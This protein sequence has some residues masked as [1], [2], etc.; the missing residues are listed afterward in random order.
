MSNDCLHKKS[1][2]EKGWIKQ[3]GN[4][5]C[6]RDGSLLP[7]GDGSMKSKVEKI[8]GQQNRS[9]M[10]AGVYPMPSRQTY[11]SMYVNKERDRR[12]SVIQD[13][14]DHMEYGYTQ[15]VSI[16]ASTM[17]YKEELHPQQYMSDQILNSI[18]SLVHAVDRQYVQTRAGNGGELDFQ[19]SQ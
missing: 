14:R 5:V 15:D 11:S 16:E 10:M 3:E 6:L 9:Q 17:D 13:L 2:L 12:D 4:Q 8:S 18:Q 7:K 19:G 1:H